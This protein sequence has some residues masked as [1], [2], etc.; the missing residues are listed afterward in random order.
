MRREI[1]RGPLTGFIKDFKS[2]LSAPSLNK[3]TAASNIEEALGSRLGCG[4]SVG[5]GLPSSPVA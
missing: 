1:R 2:R 5:L 4:L 3:P